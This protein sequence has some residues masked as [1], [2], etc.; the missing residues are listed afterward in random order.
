M[1]Q[2]YIKVLNAHTFDP[3]GSNLG[4]E[5]YRFNVRVPNV[6]RARIYVTAHVYGTKSE[7][8]C[9]VLV[10]EIMGHL[11]KSILWSLQ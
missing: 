4:F 1:E 2:F 5:P 10:I 11:Y 7:N 8:N 6:I 9:Q 3:A